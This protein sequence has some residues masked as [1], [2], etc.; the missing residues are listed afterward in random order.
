MKHLGYT[1]KKPS[2]RAGVASP[3]NTPYPDYEVRTDY[4]R[5]TPKKEYKIGIGITTHNRPDNL[6][7]SMSGILLTTE[8]LNCKIVVVDDAS[9]VPVAACQFRLQAQRGYSQGKE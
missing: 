3:V 8:G 6:R 9:D 2:N 4:V 1:G 5:H 7:R